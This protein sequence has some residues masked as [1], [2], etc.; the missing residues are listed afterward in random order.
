MAQASEQ[1]HRIE[2]PTRH[3]VAELQGKLR[4]ALDGIALDDAIDFYDKLYIL[5]ATQRGEFAAYRT[6]PVVDKLDKARRGLVML[7]A[8]R[9][10]IVGHLA[11]EHPWTFLDV[12]QEEEPA[13]LDLAVRF[14]EAYR[15]GDTQHWWHSSY[16]QT[17]PRSQTGPSVERISEEQLTVGLPVQPLGSE[18]LYTK[19]EAYSHDV[20]AGEYAIHQKVVDMQ[21]GK[22]EREQAA[23]HSAVTQAVS[24][25]C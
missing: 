5:A 17:S 20:F 11:P 13:R 4:G 16:S 21:R 23:L 19:V 24:R 10:L 2:D 18:N 25:I 3:D 8:S 1:L 14:R 9:M 22:G 12:S 6:N 15:I 7:T